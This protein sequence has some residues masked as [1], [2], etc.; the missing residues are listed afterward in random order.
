MTNILGLTAAGFMLV[1]VACSGSTTT[2][3]TGGTE[4][5]VQ[6]AGDTKGAPAAGKTSAKDAPPAA[7]GTPAATPAPASPDGNQTGTDGQPGRISVNEHCCYGATYFRCPNAVACLGG[8][9][10]DA[11][12]AACA[13]GDDAC[14]DACAVKEDAAGAPKGCQANVTPPKGVDCANGSIDL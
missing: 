7:P 3:E 1:L 6:G 13:D 10:A 5:P 4:D 2:P 11:C 14:A 8:F 9:D 12:V